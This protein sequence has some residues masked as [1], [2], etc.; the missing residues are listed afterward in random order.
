MVP[1]GSETGPI[2]YAPTGDG[3]ASALIGFNSV[4]F[5]LLSEMYLQ[6]C[7][8]GIRVLRCGPN[9]GKVSV[10][11]VYRVRFPFV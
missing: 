6:H 7:E 8:I 3:D 4:G 10:I 5:H 1:S 11:N 2:A 9:P